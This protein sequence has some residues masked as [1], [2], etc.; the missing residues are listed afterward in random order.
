[1]AVMIILITKD[2]GMCVANPCAYLTSKNYSC[3][4]MV[5]PF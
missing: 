1:M 3:F 4:N 5:S 2:S